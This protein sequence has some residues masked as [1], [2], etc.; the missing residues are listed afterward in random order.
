MAVNV[1]LHLHAWFQWVVQPGR[2]ASHSQ[3]AVGECLLPVLPVPRREFL[4]CDAR[5]LQIGKLYVGKGICIAARGS[6]E[7][8]RE[9][10]DW[11]TSSIDF[12]FH[13]LFT[14][15]LKSKKYGFTCASRLY[16]SHVTV[17]LGTAQ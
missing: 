11:K 3:P 4:H 14:L 12:P 1:V 17:A 2:S 5:Y 15:H 8:N 13:R 9:F 16:Q 7:G 6:V 10:T